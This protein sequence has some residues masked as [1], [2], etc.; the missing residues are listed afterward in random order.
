MYFAHKYLEVSSHV[1]A[2]DDKVRRPLQPPYTGPFEVVER[3]NER[4]YTIMVHGKKI[5]ISV[6]RLKPAFIPTAD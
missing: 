6:D 5:N 3:L 1:F 2:R 4:V